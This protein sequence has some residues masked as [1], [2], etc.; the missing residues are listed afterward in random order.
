VKPVKVES[1]EF[2]DL[3]SRVNNKTVPLFLSFERTLLQSLGD[4]IRK[5]R[6]DNPKRNSLNLGGESLV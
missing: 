6:E 5:I 3:S 2:L 4:N 1:L